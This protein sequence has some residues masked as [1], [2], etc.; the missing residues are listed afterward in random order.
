MRVQGRTNDPFENSS[1][2]YGKRNEYLVFNYIYPLI[3]IGKIFMS[4]EYKSKYDIGLIFFTST[5]S[6]PIIYEIALD[7]FLSVYMKKVYKVI[8]EDTTRFVGMDMISISDKYIAFLIFDFHVELQV[9]RIFDRNETFYAIGY[10]DIYLHNFEYDV[11]TLKFLDY[12]IYYNFYVRDVKRWRIYNIKEQE[13][14]IDSKNYIELFKENIN[15][16]YH[17]S[18]E[19]YSEFHSK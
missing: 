5:R 7:H 4:E 9:I 12:S 2:Q 10:T 14:V 3:N 15:L 16:T 13:L 19:A 8:N 1:G 18:I 11:C 6:P 17:I